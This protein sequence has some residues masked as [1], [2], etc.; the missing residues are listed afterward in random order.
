MCAH[1]SVE[2]LKVKIQSA[3]PLSV[4]NGTALSVLCYLDCSCG[5]AQL[6]WSRAGY[7]SLPSSAVVTLGNAGRSLTLSFPVATT[8]VGGEYVC[9]ASS[10][11]QPPANKTL[12]LQ[13]S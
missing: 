8:D 11:T 3:S 12:L 7:Q 1:F 4:S 6:S 10:G 9:T 5:G 13:V 2:M